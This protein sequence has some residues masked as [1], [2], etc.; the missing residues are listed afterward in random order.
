MGRESVVTV[1]LTLRDRASYKDWFLRHSV[2]EHFEYLILDGSTN[3]ENQRVVECWNRPNIRYMT[4]DDYVAKLCA[5]ARAV[6]TP[7]AV[8]ADNDDM[9]LSAGVGKAA[10]ALS[11][12]TDAVA[13][14]GPV[15]G[16]F[17]SGPSSD[18]MSLPLLLS[19][20]RV[21]LDSDPMKRLSEY[22]QRYSIIWNHVVRTTVLR[23]SL[24]ALHDGSVR[25]SHLIEFFVT[26]YWLL[27]GAVLGVRRP[28]Y[29]RLENQSQRAIHDVP[30]RAESDPMSAA[31]VE[32]ASK[33]DKRLLKEYFPRLRKRGLPSLSRRRLLISGTPDRHDLAHRIV[34]RMHYVTGGVDRV[35]VN[36][37]L[38]L[39]NIGFYL[40]A[41]IH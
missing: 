34:R 25:E 40:G 18:R 14:G 24:N 27:A 9:V 16:Y 19:G 10:A 39:A 11:A 15:L 37:G 4:E 32:S 38:T 41:G 23:D 29:L 1:V 3:D 8:L 35:P 28:H 30:A 21:F 17:H 7:Y 5:G 22:R 12:R 13:A 36:V 26:D 33:A 31:W 2:S 20:R 6:S